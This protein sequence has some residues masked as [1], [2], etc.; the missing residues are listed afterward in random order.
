MSTTSLLPPVSAVRMVWARTGLFSDDEHSKQ[1]TV[2][3]EEALKNI[4]ERAQSDEKENK[5]VIST[6]ATMD[7][8]LRSLDTAYKGRQLNFEENEKLRSAYL[9]SIRESLDFGKKAQ[10]F[11]RS[12]PTMTIGAAGGVTIAQALGVS[13]IKL[14]GIG[15]GLAA[16]GYIVNLLFV[17]HGR[18]KTQMLYI[19]Q[20]YERDLYYDQYI[21]RVST[22]LTSLY[23]DLDR[24]HK[25]IFGQPYPVD[26]T[27]VH[28]IIE[29]MLRGV[30]ST[31]CMYVHKHMREKKITPELW[32]LCETGA[33]DAVK[34]CPY[35]EK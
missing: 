30:R 12:L 15:L 14:W 9:D 31:F 32:S 18:K 33:L 19:V 11:L 5:Y 23:L 22:I 2:L 17:R 34:Q 1:S 35:W 3:V 26:A 24:I 4:K 8:S 13:G 21:T 7:S 28:Q 27:E 20:D 25:N 29:E 16:V 6:I 10:D